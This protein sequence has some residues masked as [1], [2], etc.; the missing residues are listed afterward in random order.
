ML[1]LAVPCHDEVRCIDLAYWLCVAL[2]WIAWL[3]NGFA[4]MLYWLCTTVLCVSVSGARL[5]LLR[6]VTGSVMAY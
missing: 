4:P 5:D 6:C 1:C 2:L 3:F